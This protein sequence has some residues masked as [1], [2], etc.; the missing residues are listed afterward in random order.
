MFLEDQPFYER[1][2][3]SRFD[4]TEWWLLSTNFEC[5]TMFLICI[6]MFQMASVALSFGSDFR[7]NLFK[8]PSMMVTSLILLVFHSILVV[9]P[10]DALL[11]AYN[12]ILLPETFR[13]KLWGL[14]LGLSFALAIFQKA[15]FDG[16]FAT[17]FRDAA[18]RRKQRRSTMEV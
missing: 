8:S 15:V 3:S 7:Q 11:S 18:R 17:F 13:W 5:T 9:A 14:C 1:F 10:S 16:P 6:F 12:M 2:D 4:L